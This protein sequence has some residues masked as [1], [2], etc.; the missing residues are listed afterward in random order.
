MCCELLWHVLIFKRIALQGITYHEFEWCVIDQVFRFRTQDMQ[1][2][3]D[4]YW[5]YEK[6]PSPALSV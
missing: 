5:E 4:V 3:V 1:D 6:A 2:R